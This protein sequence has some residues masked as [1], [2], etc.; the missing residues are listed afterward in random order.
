LYIATQHRSGDLDECTKTS[1]THHL[2]EFGKLRFGTE[3]LYLLTYV[4]PASTKQPDPPPLYDWKIFGGAAVVHA[5]P[6]TTVSTFDSY[7]ENVFFP[8][9]LNRLQSSKRVDI[10]WDTYKANIVKDSTREKGGKG[11]RRK[12]T[13]DTKIPPDWKAFF[14]DNT[15][16]KELFAL[17]TSRVSNFQLPENK[18][19][20]ITSDESVVSSRGSTDKQRCDHEEADTRIGLHVQHALN[21]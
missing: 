14:Q 18:E 21:K 19:V 4:K 17:L 10:V 5:L 6:S 2:S 15:N 16:K 8:F 1:P 9:I 3:K 11:Q 7:T 20:N 13:G 12:I